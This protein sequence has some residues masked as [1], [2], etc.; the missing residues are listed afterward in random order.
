MRIAKLKRQL[1]PIGKRYEADEI[2]KDEWRAKGD[3]LRAEIH[4]LE[5]STAAPV[6]PVE[7]LT[8]CQQWQTGDAAQRA[9]VLAALW[10][11]I[12]V[13]GRKVVKLTSRADRASRA[14]A[15][16]AT[17]LQYV[18]GGSSTSRTLP[19]NPTWGQALP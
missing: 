19:L 2:T 12:E 6:D 8:L 3:K 9:A 13:R 5:A 10:E 1:Q 7:L 4:T 14:H 16:I 15:F 17:A 11:R 18:S